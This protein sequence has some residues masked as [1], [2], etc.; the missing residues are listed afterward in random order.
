MDHRGGFRNGR[1]RGSSLFS[2]QAAEGRDLDSP[3]EGLSADDLASGG[4][5][6]DRLAGVLSLVEP[7][8]AV[9]TMRLPVGVSHPTSDPGVSHYPA[10]TA[11]AHAGTAQAERPTAPRQLAKP[12]LAIAVPTAT[13]DEKQGTAEVGDAGTGSAVG[14]LALAQQLHDQYVSEG[15]STRERLISEGQLR[16]DQV[17]GEAET[18][19]EELLSTGKAKYEE[20]IS[21]GEAKHDALIDEAEAIVAKANAEHEHLIT[22]ARERSTKMVTEAQQKKAEVLEGLGSERSLLEQQIEEMR[23][24][25]RDHRARLKSYLE[26]ALIELNQTG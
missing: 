23:T 12:A 7:A 20:L 15:Q 17:V 13:N 16:H 14:M 4:L 18:R 21:V 26:D 10:A 19:Q 8:P 6:A 24:L 3:I 25:E 22:E 9:P 11:S 2:S 1:V 5:T